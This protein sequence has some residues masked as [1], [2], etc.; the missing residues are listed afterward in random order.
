MFI[1]SKNRPLSSSPSSVAKSGIINANRAAIVT[2]SGAAG[3]IAIDAATESGL[4]V[5]ALSSVTIDKLASLSPRLASNPVDVGQVA[6]LVN[7]GDFTATL[8]SVMAAVLADSGVDCAIMALWATSASEAEATADMFRRLRQQFSKALAIWIYGPKLSAR[9]ELSRQLE[10]LGVPTY[11][12]LETAA[13]ALGIAA[14]YA[15]VK[16]RHNW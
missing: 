14:T 3:I 7:V 11:L 15:K 8:E 4:T 13:K 10:V 5:A 9:D 12:N 6:T 1:N 16:S 2:V